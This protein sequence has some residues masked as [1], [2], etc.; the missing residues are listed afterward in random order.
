MYSLSSLRSN[1]L[2]ARAHVGVLLGLC[3]VMR[4]L[5]PVGYMPGNLLAGEFMILCPQGV[6]AEFSGNFHSRCFHF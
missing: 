5:I 2:R 3:V 4:A 6:P 1:A